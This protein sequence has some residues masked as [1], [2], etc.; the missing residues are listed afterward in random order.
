MKSQPRTNSVRRLTLATLIAI[1]LLGHG[2][3]IQ[4]GDALAIQSGSYC[5]LPEPGEIPACSGD[6]NYVVAANTIAWS[7]RC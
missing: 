7:L 5:M 4:A 3:V 1:P 2:S 6:E